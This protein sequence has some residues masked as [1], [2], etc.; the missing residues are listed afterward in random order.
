MLR[1]LIVDDHLIVRE[2]LKQLVEAASDRSMT[3][4]AC[5]SQAAIKLLRTDAHDVVLLGAVMTGH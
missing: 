3:A 5:S 1:V 4:E 2:G